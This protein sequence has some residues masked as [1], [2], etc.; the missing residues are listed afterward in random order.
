VSVSG[1]ARAIQDY[2]I[3]E[4]AALIKKMQA[5]LGQAPMLNDSKPI[6]SSN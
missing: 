3:D 2:T 6:L 1:V 4:M 5:V